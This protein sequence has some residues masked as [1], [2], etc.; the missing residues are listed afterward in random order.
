M[1]MKKANSKESWIDKRDTR[2]GSIF[3]LT[4][5]TITQRVLLET[6]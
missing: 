4:S 5:R 6:H 1:R 3:L 2:A